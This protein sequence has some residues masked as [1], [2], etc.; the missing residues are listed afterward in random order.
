MMGFHFTQTLNIRKTGFGNT[1]MAE[2]GVP[3]PIASELLAGSKL[4]D[5][6]Q[7]PYV[8][9][10][11]YGNLDGSRYPEQAVSDC[12]G[13]LIMHSRELSFNQ[14][15]AALTKVVMS[16][17]YTEASFWGLPGND[18]TG[19]IRLD[20]RVTVD[21]TLTKVT[22]EVDY[23]STVYVAYELSRVAFQ[24]VKVERN[25]IEREFKNV[26]CLP[27]SSW[28]NASGTFRMWGQTYSWGSEQED[29]L[30]I[31]FREIRKV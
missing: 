4:V 18:L 9:K 7:H 5:F 30:T 22:F 24:W 11:G 14:Q 12:Y 23:D 15:Y 27:Q 19:D 3:T 13:A 20:D 29:F 28:R 25:G 2:L 1:C 26:A 31:P 8:F 16:K 21:P 17:D 6:D 10:S